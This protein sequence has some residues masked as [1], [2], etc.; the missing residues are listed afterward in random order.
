MYSRTPGYVIVLSRTFAQTDGKIA[1]DYDIQSVTVD[2]YP[3]RARIAVEVLCVVLLVLNCL[4]EL[5]G[6]Y[7]Q[8]HV[9]FG[10][11]LRVLMCMNFQVI[12]LD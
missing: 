1:W 12:K 8:L 10:K 2:V 9:K 4:S 5:S 11:I 3:E 6:E 7:K